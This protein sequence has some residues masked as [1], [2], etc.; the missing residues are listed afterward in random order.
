[1]EQDKR[2]GKVLE[3]ARSYI[4]LRIEL[5][6]L[7][8]GEKAAVVIA[9]IITRGLAA[10]LFFFS[11]LFASIGLAFHLGRETGTSGGF[12]IVAG[13]YL[14]FA[15]IILLLGKPLIQPKLINFLIRQFFSQDKHE[16]SED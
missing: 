10:F 2:L 7:Q 8:M 15:I 1:M 12:F 3:D 14:L 6:K 9:G 16:S 4:D 13:A 11:F 5:A